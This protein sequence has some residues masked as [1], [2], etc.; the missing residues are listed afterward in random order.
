MFVQACF[1]VRVNA[2][3][4]CPPRTEVVLETRAAEYVPVRTRRPRAFWMYARW[5]F[6]QV[7]L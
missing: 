1:Y 7:Q 6:A 3:F 5:V 4:S 2:S